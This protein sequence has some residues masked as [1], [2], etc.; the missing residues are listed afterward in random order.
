MCQPHDLFGHWHN[1]MSPVFWTRDESF[2][3][4]DGSV[5]HDSQLRIIV[6]VYG[7]VINRAN[8]WLSSPSADDLEAAAVANSSTFRVAMSFESPEPL[9]SGFFLSAAEAAAGA[10]DLF[11]SCRRDVMAL[12]PR[13]LAMFMSCGWA[14]GSPAVDEWHFSADDK[15]QLVSMQA[16]TSNF[17][18]GH[19]LR[20]QA[21][22]LLKDRVHRFGRG[23]SMYDTPADYLKVATPSLVHCQTHFIPKPKCSR[24]P[25]T[26]PW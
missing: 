9:I 17:T 26:F 12:L 24:R 14:E 4:L 2:A 20:L 18:E 21:S 13:R 22:E 16:S 23:Y 10:F 15:T 6:Y 25:S 19:A 3:W 11:L 8:A 1:D 5:E 7:G